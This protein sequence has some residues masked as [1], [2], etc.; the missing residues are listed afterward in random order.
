MTLEV[1]D[2]VF[3]KEAPKPKSRLSADVLDKLKREFEHWYPVDLRS[4]G[5]DLVPNHLSYFLYNH[6]AIWPGHRYVCN[7]VL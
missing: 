7:I 5:K 1:W 6:A 2:Y 4:S 3:F